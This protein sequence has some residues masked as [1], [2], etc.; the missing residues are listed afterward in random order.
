MHSLFHFRKNF[1]YNNYFLTFSL[2]VVLIDLWVEH[3]VLFF[4]FVE[5]ARV[6]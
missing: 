5:I 1:N 6:V 3:S 2:G 4:F